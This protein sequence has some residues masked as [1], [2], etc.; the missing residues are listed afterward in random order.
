MEAALATLV[1]GVGDCEGDDGGEDVGWSDEEEGLYFGVAE[2]FDERGDEGCYGAGGGLGYDDEAGKRS[3]S[4]WMLTL[5]IEQQEGDGERCRR[6]GKR[7]LREKPD[8]V[9]ED[10]H[11]HT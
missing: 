2:C 8:F 5:S 1:T 3:V 6:G 9:V 7:S 4:S 10:S 11:P